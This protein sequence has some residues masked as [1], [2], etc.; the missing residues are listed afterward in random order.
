MIFLQKGNITEALLFWVSH[1]HDYIYLTHYTS[2][3]WQSMGKGA[4][5]SLLQISR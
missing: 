4:H 2:L 5:F 1:E 3:I